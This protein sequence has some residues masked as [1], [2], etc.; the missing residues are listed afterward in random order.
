V[1]PSFVP[2][3]C[4]GFFKNVSKNAVQRLVEDINIL[5]KKKNEGIP[6]D[7]LLKPVK[8]KHKLI[9]ESQT[10]QGMS[11]SNKHSVV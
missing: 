4:G 3:F 6:F 7:E 2:P 9:E 8:D 5:I 11:L 1:L 10:D